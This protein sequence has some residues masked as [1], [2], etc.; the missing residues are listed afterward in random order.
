MM[1]RLAATGKPDDLAAC[2]AFIGDVKDSAVRRRALEGLTM[3]L[4]NRQLDP[5]EGW[6]TVLAS[7]REDKDKD[8]RS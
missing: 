7:L 8:V 3:A 1:R 5:P 4:Q 2:I 6:K